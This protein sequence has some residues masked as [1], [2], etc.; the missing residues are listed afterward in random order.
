MIGRRDFITL[1]GGAAAAWPLAAR[2]QQGD[3]L[4]RLGMLMGNPEDVLS[5][6][7]KQL[8]EGLAPLG[9]IEGRNLRVDLR[10]VGSNDPAIIR[11]HAE[12][13]VRSAPDIIYASPATAVQVLQPLTSSI[14]IVFVQ[15][16]DP[17]QTGAVQS[18]AHP[19]GNMTG[20]LGFEPSINSKLLQLLKDIA[21]QMTR[22]A[23]MQTEVTRAARGGSDF[24]TVAEAAKS[25]SITSVD[26]L[27]RDD[28]ADMERALVGFAQQPNGGLILAP[29]GATA[30]HR[31]L[32]APLAIK[33]RVPSVATFRQFVDSGGLMYYSAALVDPRRVA[34]Y[35]DRILRG[36]NPGELPV[37]TPD[38]FNLVVNLKT[39]TALG[40]TIP[41][42][43][44]ALAD[45][46]IE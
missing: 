1:L 26:L 32:L 5:A 22:V 14:P 42:S 11:P 16:T 43:L 25:L 28:G 34:S 6:S 37:V 10:L 21:P 9:W 33:L 46:V 15:N 7:A 38:K 8:L 20:F 3:R 30:R 19:G 13:L 29:D 44:F 27:V 12:G 17:V 18:L 23:V 41:P 24:A 31:E 2:A 36:T 39:A 45:E 35:I 40:L 4:K